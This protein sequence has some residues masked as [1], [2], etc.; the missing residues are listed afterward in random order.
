MENP[1]GQTSVRGGGE[2]SVLTDRMA[3]DIDAAFT[4]GTMLL[5]DVP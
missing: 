3:A 2:G 1:E 4:I 5:A